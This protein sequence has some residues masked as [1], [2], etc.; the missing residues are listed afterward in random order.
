[1]L[2]LTVFLSGSSSAD[3]A[4]PVHAVAVGHSDYSVTSFCDVC[5]TNLSHYTAKTQKSQSRM[6]LRKVS[7]HRGHIPCFLPRVTWPPCWSIFSLG[8]LRAN[9]LSSHVSLIHTCPCF[10]VAIWMYLLRSG[11]YQYPCS[12]S[13]NSGI[14]FSY[15]SS[16]LIDLIYLVNENT[17]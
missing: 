10:S 11:N 1:M 6:V 15:C 3:V 7:G 17:L 5:R 8:F 12:P 4:H 14:K 2:H 16:W 13:N 9:N